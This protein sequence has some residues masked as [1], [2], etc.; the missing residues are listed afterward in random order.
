MRLT[1]KDRILLHLLESTPMG[2]NL[3]VPSDLTQVGLTRGAGIEQ[4][5]LSQSLRP[6]MEEGLVH[7]RISHVAGKR[8]RMRVYELTP[9]GRK[10]AASLRE[11][12]T[13][14]L[15]RV[16]VGDTVREESLDRVLR[17]RSERPRLLEALRQVDQA[18]LL[19]FESA[20][21]APESGRVEQIRDAPKVVAFF[22]RREELAELLREGR[23]P[24]LYV[25]RGIAGI[26]KSTL[27]AR[28]CELARGRWN[29]LWH[30]VRPWESSLAVLASLG[31]FLEALDRPGLSSVL[32]RGDS[33][34]LGE[35]L[36]QDL[37]DTHA[38]LVWD[39]VHEGAEDVLQVFRMLLEAASTASDVRILI[40]TRRSLPFYDVRDLAPSG[41]VREI[42]L[43]GLPPED[44]AAFLAAGGITDL[45]AAIGR[46]LAG[47]P[48]F[49]E[50]VR[51]RHPSTGEGL[52]DVQ[53]FIEETVYRDLSD[54]ER[55]L[56]KANCLY[57][58]TVPQETLLHVPGSS[59]EALLA[60]KNRAL[61]RSVGGDRY[62]IHDTVRE[63]LRGT[64]TP[65]ERQAYS[66]AAVAQLRA[67][68]SI[69]Q[70]SG[71]PVACIDDLSNALLLARSREDRLDLC[72]ALGD[73]DEQIGDSSGSAMAYQRALESAQGPEAAARLHRKMARATMER[74][75]MAIA[76]REIEAGSRALGDAR[77]VEEGWLDLLRARAADLDGDDF[78]S[79]DCAERAL[80]TFQRFGDRAGQ[81]RAWLQLGAASNWTGS[82][83]KDGSR[84]SDR[85]FAKAIELAETLHDPALTAEAHL[86][87]AE[88]M[89]I[90]RGDYEEVARHLAAVQASPVA[91]SEPFIRIRFHWVR[92]FF[93]IRLKMDLDAAEADTV[94]LERLARK[95]HDTRYEALVVDVRETIVRLR[96]ERPEDHRQHLAAA[97]RLAAAG[98]GLYASDIYSSIALDALAAGDPTGF[99]KAASSALNV[100][101]PSKGVL[102]VQHRVLDALASLL[103]GER[104]ESERIFTKVM[105]VFDGYPPTSGYHPLQRWN[106]EFL[107]SIALR[108]MGRN[109]EASKHLQHAVE[110]ARVSHNRQALHWMASSFAADAARALMASGRSPRIA[111]T[112]SRS[113]S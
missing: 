23:D 107:Y 33:D 41:I 72:E 86:M 21:H 1:A 75:E 47:H 3:E 5:H 67:L 110:L 4:R 12:L 31:R 36:R 32:K 65:E 82:V 42:E 77:C 102:W 49:L 63:F 104:V 64:L 28:A 108:A 27:A 54:A 56:L 15:V 92:A 52:H 6:L 20:G 50:L 16:R 37:P 44:T 45:P 94:E 88:P 2:A 38:L 96:G 78:Q 98:L 13:S 29:L 59:F 113:A 95:I 79:E 17:A 74:G 80:S 48:L 84:V 101:H 39:D 7:E 93:L 100:C 19:D 60:L 68:A 66:D 70:E 97:E 87:M 25:V 61:V 69:A 76:K 14:Q 26:G 46:R 34:V 18:G 103:D 111:S 112:A 109:T 89:G 57:E 105:R 90:Q 51:S 81:V 83:L 73:V 22:G 71:D 43:G 99:R 24:R 91:W 30:R 53:R 55:S 106:V 11:A 58:V 10:Y 62:T 35:V 9:S 85:A 8:Q 40:L